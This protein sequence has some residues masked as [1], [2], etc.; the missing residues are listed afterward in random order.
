MVHDV[1]KWMREPEIALDHDIFL[2]MILENSSFSPRK[3]EIQSR[4]PKLLSYSLVVKH[5]VLK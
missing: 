5:F 1:K 2:K 3:L 4:L